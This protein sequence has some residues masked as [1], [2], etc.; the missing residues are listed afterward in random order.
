MAEYIEREAFRDRLIELVR[1]TS[2][3]HQKKVEEWIL[4]GKVGDRPS[5]SESMAD[6]VLAADVAPVVRCKDCKKMQKDEIFGGMWC[7]RMTGTYRVNADVFC[8][9][10]EREGE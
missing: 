10:G 4:G 6:S 5:I 3:V 7:N 9:Y 1:D 2:N 8:S